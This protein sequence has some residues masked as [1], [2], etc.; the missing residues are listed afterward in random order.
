MINVGLLVVVIASQAAA[1]AAPLRADQPYTVK[2]A[3]KDGVVDL[4]V[5]ADEAQ[6]TDVATDLSKRLRAQVIVGPSLAKET[7]TVDVPASPLEAALTSLAPR[8]LIDYEIRPDAKPMPRGIFLLGATDNDP[9]TD[10]I[11]RGMSQGLL[12][13]G[14][15]EDTPKS[16]EEDPLRVTGDKNLI[17]IVVK[18]QPLNIVARA[19][20]D[21]IGVPVDVRYDASELIELDVRNARPEELL[22]RISPNVRLFVRVDVNRAERTLLRMVIAPPS[23]RE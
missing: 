18:K 12:I 19:I 6:L 16:E 5:K 9:A 21:V 3:A 4:A 8:V 10:T 23:E 7:I 22:P 13:E 1:Q 2:V 20:A 11:A 14:H 17:S 15:T